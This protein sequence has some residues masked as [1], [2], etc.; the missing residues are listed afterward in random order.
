M[1]WSRDTIEQNLE[2]ACNLFPKN[3]WANKGERGCVG[4]PRRASVR[5][6]CT[7]PGAG[8]DH[9]TA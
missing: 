1:L 7:E 5:C 8:V 6:R 3:C 9:G 2:P 4:A